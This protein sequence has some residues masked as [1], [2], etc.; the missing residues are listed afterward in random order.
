MGEP[1]EGAVAQIEC[2]AQQHDKG[3]GYEQA[4]SNEERRQ[5][6]EQEAKR[7]Q[8]VRCDACSGNGSGD[9]LGYGAGNGV[10]EDGRHVIRIVSP[11]TLEYNA[12]GEAEVNA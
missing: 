7:R 11:R 12:A 8:L 5:H 4:Q 6:I 10:R 9:G 2:T 1:S 3:S